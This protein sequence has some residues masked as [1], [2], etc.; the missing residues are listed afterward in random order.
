MS[1]NCFALRWAGKTFTM[2]PGNPNYKHKLMICRNKKFVRSICKDKLEITS[3]KM[4]N[5]VKNNIIFNMYN[6]K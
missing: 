1:T 6:K 3:K 4:F 5:N 2:C